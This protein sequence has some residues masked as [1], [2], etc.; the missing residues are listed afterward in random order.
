MFARLSQATAGLRRERI[1]DSP[2]LNIGPPGVMRLNYTAQKKKNH[3]EIVY[4]RN[5]KFQTARKSGS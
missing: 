5:R 1:T 2:F 3:F 4:E